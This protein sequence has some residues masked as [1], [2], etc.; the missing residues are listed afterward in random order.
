MRLPKKNIL[1]LGG[2]PLLVHS[3]RYAKHHRELLQEIVVSTD[4]EEIAEIAKAEGVTVI[5]RPAAISGAQATTVSALQHTLEQFEDSFDHLILLQ[6]TNPFRPARLLNE[7]FAQFRKRNADS[8]MT[9]ST[10]SQKLGKIEEGRFVPF[11]YVMGQRSQD[12]EPLYFENGLLYIAKTAL[13]KTGKILG[14]DN[15]PMIVDHPFSQ[16]DIDDLDDFEY[17]EYVYQK[18]KDD[19]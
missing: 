12:L 16:V 10:H 1:P 8:L 19:A 17:A 11:N 14:E 4:N 13:I 6:P 15:V 3:I 5:E 7:A 18:M 2:L 9:V